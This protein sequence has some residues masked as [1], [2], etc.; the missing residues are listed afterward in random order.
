MMDAPRSPHT[1]A[2]DDDTWLGG[3]GD[4]TPSTDAAC[5]LVGCPTPTLVRTALS[6][7]V[8]A[9]L[10]ILANLMCACTGVSRMRRKD[11]VAEIE[12]CISG[13]EE[14][15]LALFTRGSMERLHA[16]TRLRECVRV[17]LHLD[18]LPR[19]TGGG[20]S[21]DEDDDD[22][23]DDDDVSG[24]GDVGGCTGIATEYPETL[25]ACAP[26]VPLLPVPRV[27]GE[28]AD[29]RQL[30]Y[31]QAPRAEPL[32]SPV[33]LQDA[34]RA[35]PFYSIGASDTDAY[36]GS[37]A[38]TTTQVRYNVPIAMDFP[39]LHRKFGTCSAERVLLFF[40]SQPGGLQ[41]TWPMSDVDVRFDG[42]TLPK[43][44]HECYPVDVTCEAI[45]GG[46]VSLLLSC[47]R[48]G[49]DQAAADLYVVCVVCS[50]DEI[51]ASGDP[52][53]FLAR[54][55]PVQQPN[56]VSID[57]N[58]TMVAMATAATT[59]GEDEESCGAEVRV[60]IACP[61]SMFRL[62][63]PVRTTTC[64]HAQCFDMGTFFRMQAMARVPKWKCPECGARAYP[65]DLVVDSV[66]AEA[67]ASPTLYA[68]ATHVVIDSTRTTWKFEGGAKSA[69]P[70]P[71]P[72][73]E[74]AAGGQSDSA[75]SS[76]LSSP[77]SPPSASPDQSPDS[78][79]PLVDDDDDDAVAPTGVSHDTSAAWAF[80]MGNGAGSEQS[81][82]HSLVD[83]EYDL[84][85]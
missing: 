81:A 21:D 11:L 31:V 20:P 23:D 70:P 16:N 65:D 29:T 17:Q 74:P 35:L 18:E 36:Y 75:D 47:S 15:G 59:G 68:S 58:A 84:S 67:L 72:E 6:T 9:D 46:S 8:V 73:P 44:G 4:G 60:S 12:R 33:T 54:R 26:L 63:V 10:G 53:P 50:L 83:A 69:P 77:Y 22:D 82:P 13:R 48:F 55:D 49:Q 43:R 32:A 1:D 37:P 25:T 5:V 27:P 39:S 61:L 79:M 42:M 40:V 30:W 28:R 38:Y 41:L 2:L 85:L 19:P 34:A 52:G 51:S 3:G 66:V 64:L 45:H 14:L 56:T 76:A 62:D 24:G 80:W 57:A 78:P 71:S 7:C